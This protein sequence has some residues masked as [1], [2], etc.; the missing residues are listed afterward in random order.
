MDEQPTCFGICFD[1]AAPECKICAASVRCSSSSGN[2]NGKTIPDE[3][4]EPAQPE[5]TEVDEGEDVTPFDHLVK[6]LEGRFDREDKDGDLAYG[7]FFLKAGNL[8][9][10]VM[11]SKNT[12]RVKIKTRSFE[13]L[14]DSVESIES[15][16]DAEDMLGRMLT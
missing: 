1:A 13:R 8:A 6:S 16:E 9:A 7:I 12:G 2:R 4:E 14:L 10:Q 3:P 15:I 5:F 11:I